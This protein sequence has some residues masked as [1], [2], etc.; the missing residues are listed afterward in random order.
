MSKYRTAQALSQA[1]TPTP[2]Q[3][4]IPTEF[5][6][7]EYS[8]V[9]AISDEGKLR[10]IGVDFNRVADSSTWRVEVWADFGTAKNI[11]TQARRAINRDGRIA[12]ARQRAAA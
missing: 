1:P 5:L 3:L 2:P 4:A 7:D 10:D 11:R 8:L 12:A 9:T 6:T